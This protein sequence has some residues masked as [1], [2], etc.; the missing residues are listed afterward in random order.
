ML[1][2]RSKGS[3]CHKGKVVATEDLPVDA[4]GGEAPHF[5]SNRSEEEEGVVTQVMSVLLSSTRGVTLT[6]IFW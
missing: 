4:M 3:S 5:E 1:Q 6:S 2:T